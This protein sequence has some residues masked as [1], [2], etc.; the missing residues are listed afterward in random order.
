MDKSLIIRS[1]VTSILNEDNEILF[2]TNLQFFYDIEDGILRDDQLNKY[3]KTRITNTDRNLIYNLF[4]NTYS[5]EENILFFQKFN[6]KIE[7]Y[8]K[9]DHNIANIDT[10]FSIHSIFYR[11]FIKGGAALKVFVDN[12]VTLGIIGHDIPLIPNIAI[13][14]TDIDSNIIVNPSFPEVQELIV[15]LKQVIKN[16]SLKM[17]E[18]YNTIFCKFSD[19]LVKKIQR[20][21]DFVKKISSL[22]GKDI[23]ISSPSVEESKKTLP[24]NGFSIKPENSCVR[25]TFLNTQICI[26]RILL[27]VN[28]N[29][30]QLIIHEVEGKE[31]KKNEM[32]ITN[33]VF[34][35]EAEAELIDITLYEITYPKY[36]DIWEWA[37]QALPYD[38]RHTLFQGIHEMIID[39]IQMNA[40]AQLSGNA[41]LIAKQEKRK[42]RIDYL[43]FLYCNYRLIQ[44]I[45]ENKNEINEK[46]VIE[47]CHKLVEA[48]F[49]Q[50]GLS[51]NQINQILPYIIGKTTV[52][53]EHIIIDF[54][55]KYIMVDQSFQYTL[56]NL[57][58]VLVSS[59][60]DKSNYTFIFPSNAIKIVEDY[61]MTSIPTLSKKKS[62][63]LFISLIQA[64]KDTY[65]DGNTL[66]IFMCAILDKVG[67]P[68]AQFVPA[69]VKSYNSMI[70]FIKSADTKLI[71]SPK[72]SNLFQKGSFPPNFQKV[73]LKENIGKLCSN[74]INLLKIGIDIII[75]N[76]HAPFKIL[77]IPKINT[78]ILQVLESIF[79]IVNSYLI[80][81]GSPY[82]ILF[83]LT[84]EYIIN[85]YFRFEFTKIINEINLEGDVD[86]HFCQ[87]MIKHQELPQDIVSLYENQGNTLYQN[88]L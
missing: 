42:M 68:I 88:M 75:L 56:S 13:D 8:L 53:M 61:I 58:G 38:R 43:Y 74:I 28:I 11:F 87:F 32:G 37:K 63:L 78:N 4:L 12:L 81:L 34:L 86:I 30:S 21:D 52:D 10:I 85:V 17:F 6:L 70:K 67:M 1:L 73:I 36:N 47:Y 14:P 19:I 72:Y 44:V 62:T 3:L 2:K 18:K 84:P 39:M 49:L 80:R 66:F 59:K 71:Q 20:N 46:H 45:L 57:E 27:C 40:D 16:V 69:V 25:L 35:T 15:I 23:F 24:N 26:I 83:E 54:I 60:L 22:F 7:K 5:G 33:S 76:K 29:E 31:N 51:E 55:K 48:P 41:S 79:E 9:S 82:V 50:L 77:C 65:I 64:Y